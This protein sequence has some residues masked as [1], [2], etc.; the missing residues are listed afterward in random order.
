MK[1]IFPALILLCA[2]LVRAQG[3]YEIQVY[4]V[5]TVAPRSTMVELH[6]NFTADGQRRPSSGVAAHQSRRARN[7][8]NHPGRQQVVRGRLLHLHQRAERPGRP[9]G[10]RPHPSPRPR[11]GKMALAGRRQPLHRDRLPARSL[12]A[13]H[14]DLGDSPHRRQNHRPLVLR[15]QSRS[16][17]HLARPRRQPGHRLLARRQNQL[18]LYK[19]DH[20]RLRVLRR[21]RQHHQHR[22]PAQSAAAALP[23]HRPQPLTRLG[24]QLRRRHRPHRRHRPLD[25]KRHHRPPLQLGKAQRLSLYRTSSNARIV[26]L[27]TVSRSTRSVRT[28]YPRP[29]VSGTAISPCAETP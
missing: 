14:L 10:R 26:S 16:R 29:G 5:E 21:L 8:R 4:G 27:R 2:A 13:R 11:P 20:R 6:S 17:A 24:D 9:M 19:K 7:H 28:S 1:F 3:N 22:Q 15:R 23:R 18:R 12:L 25:R